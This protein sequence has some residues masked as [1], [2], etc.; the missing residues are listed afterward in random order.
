MLRTKVKDSSI[1]NEENN[2]NN[3]K[4]K[5]IKIKKKMHKKDRNKVNK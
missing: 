1:D 4:S 3:D 5:R 2:I